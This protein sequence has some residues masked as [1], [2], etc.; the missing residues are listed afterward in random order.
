MKSL[1]VALLATGALALG[2][3][4]ARAAYPGYYLATFTTP[5]G[6]FQHCFQLVQTQQ[7]LSE[8]YPYSGT[9][10][11]T[12]YPDTSGTWVVYSNV[13]HLAGTVNGGGYLALDGRIAKGQLEKATFDFFDGTGTYFSAGSMTEQR[14]SCAGAARRPN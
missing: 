14:M 12:D 3:T 8:G 1:L 9:W 5:S 4:S 6:P 10:T 7:F 11:D 2:A 13:I